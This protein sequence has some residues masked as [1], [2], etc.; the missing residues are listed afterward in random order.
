MMDI[1]VLGGT[2]DPIHNGHLKIADY[3][4]VKLGLE[5]VLFVPAGQPWLKGHR[6][7][8]SGTQ[9]LEMVRLAIGS[10]SY[11]AI[12]TVDLDRKGP[13]YTEDTLRELMRELGESVNL[14]FIVGID[15][16][17]ELPTWRHPDRII[18]MCHLV[19]MKRPISATIDMESLERS[20]PGITQRSI[21]LDNPPVDISSTAIR[22]RVASGLAI[23]DLVPE[24]VE[25]YIGEHAL[26]VAA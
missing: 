4:I 7:I 9:R 23:T 25:R 22:K 8:A 5:R 18:D 14:Y 12:S 1:G 10:N 24:A 2:F 17:A 26:Y 13:S 3:A 11:F 19:V 21:F 6:F 16:L 20:V 15:A